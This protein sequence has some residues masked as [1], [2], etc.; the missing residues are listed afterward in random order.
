MKHYEFKTSRH[1]AHLLPHICLLTKIQAPDL[2]LAE[3]I[4]WVFEASKLEM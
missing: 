2:V 4:G 1:P 3:G